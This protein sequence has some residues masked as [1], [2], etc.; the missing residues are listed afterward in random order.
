MSPRAKHELAR[1]HLSTAQH[2]LDGGA[3][4]P[5]IMFLHLAAEAAVVALAES[6]GIDTRR[7]HDLKADAAGE[8]FRR[9]VVTE[10]LSE[11]LRSLNQVRKDATYEGE[12]P[13]LSAEDL[14]TLAQ[15]IATIVV[16]A[17]RRAG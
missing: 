7:R 9:G 16:A 17:E 1:K 11:V 15:R 4:V 12:D 5:A 3:F 14:E 8:L 2:E 13:D 10:D 6:V